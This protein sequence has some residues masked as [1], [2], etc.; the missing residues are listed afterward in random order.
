MRRRDFIAAITASVAAACSSAAPEDAVGSST[1]APLPPPT[2]P[3]TALSP[4][5]SSTEPLAVDLVTPATVP[6]TGPELLD[7][8]FGLGVA[9][10]DP[11]HESVVLW[12]KVFPVTGS[13]V[14]VSMAYDI[15]LDDGFT[16][17]VGSGLVE[18]A[19]SDAFTARV[20]VSGLGSNSRF[21]YR[22]RTH[23]YTSPVGRTRT[24]PAP[25]E[26]PDRF[27]LAVS[28]CQSRAYPEFW[29]WHLELATDQTV[30]MV[31]W[32]GDFIYER[33]DSRS[34]DDYRDLY[35]TYRGDE[36]LQASSAAHPWIFTWDDHEVAN[37]Y[38]R[39]VDRERRAAGYQTWWEH[40]PTRLPRPTLEGLTVYRSLDVGGLA[41]LLLLDCRQY[42]DG[43]TVLGADQLA[44]LARASQHD[45]V[46]TMV[47][48]PVIASSLEVED[49]LPPYAFE[50]HPADQQ[51]LLAI[52]S[53]SPKPFIVSGDLHAAMEMEF[54]PG[55]PEWM[56][57]PL[58]S[59]FPAEFV[60]YLPFLPLVSPAV[61]RAEPSHGYLQVELTPSSATPRFPAVP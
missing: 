20:V 37:D 51:Q 30:D 35:N 22:F 58:S 12:T 9:S 19:P 47:C 26:L 3:T 59:V 48:S 44:W 33:S 55:I 38:T 34:V 54:A 4:T 13:V 5:I 18:A 36:R 49:V 42:Q 1:T 6:S 50:A 57:P 41:R 17:V 46:H 60:Q 15:A 31:V 27:G 16:K 29:D 25:G 10:G 28:S 40:T 45:R 7:V 56:A 61:T 2:E 39:N 24:M 8:P 11:D 21:W 32:L 53:Q 23:D 43:D 14:P 52:L